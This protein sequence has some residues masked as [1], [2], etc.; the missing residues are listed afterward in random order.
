MKNFLQETLDRI[1]KS[2]E[3]ARSFNPMESAIGQMELEL[4]LLNI[5]QEESAEAEQDLKEAI[6]ELTL[7]VEKAEAAEA[8]RPWASC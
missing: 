8:G 2:G 5:L 6:D 4:E 1:K 3:R 7:V